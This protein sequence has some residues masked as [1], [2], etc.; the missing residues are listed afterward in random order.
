MSTQ[1]D[2]SKNVASDII[3]RITE[4]LRELDPSGVARGFVIGISLHGIQTIALLALFFF[5][6]PLPENLPMPEVY[7]Y[8]AFGVFLAAPKMVLGV[9]RKRS[10][11]MEAEEETLRRIER[12]VKA[13]IITKE[14]AATHF[15][16]LINV[17]LERARFTTEIEERIRAQ[18]AQRKKETEEAAE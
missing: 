11:E 9:I 12:G 8:V 7:H 17:S 13:E 3:N 6:V 4:T 15:R 5:G 2:D 10:P 14:E 16:H 1:G 18:E